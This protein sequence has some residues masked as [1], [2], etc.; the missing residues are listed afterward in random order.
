MIDRGEKIWLNDSAVPSVNLLE[1]NERKNRY[2]VEKQADL[3][4]VRHSA[5]KTWQFVGT[6]DK[7]TKSAVFQL[8][9]YPG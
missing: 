4:L 3:R 1:K 2:N 9:P 8:K 7:A 5:E 6:Q